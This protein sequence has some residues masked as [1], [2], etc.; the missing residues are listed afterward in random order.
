MKLRLLL[1]VLLIANAGYF[2]WERG[3]LAGLGLAPAALSERG[4]NRRRGVTKA[5]CGAI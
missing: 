3:D 5:R 1:V 2:L 4:C